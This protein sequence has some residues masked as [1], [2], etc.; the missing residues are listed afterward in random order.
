[1]IQHLQL[2][3]ALKKHGLLPTLETIANGKVIHGHRLQIGNESLLYR[4]RDD[5]ISITHYQTADN[6]GLN[7]RFKSAF[8]FLAI[9]AQALPNVQMMRADVE[10]QTQPSLPATMS[11][12]RMITFYQRKH[13]ATVY[14]RAQG[15]KWVEWSLDNIRQIGANQPKYLHRIVKEYYLEATA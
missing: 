9:V 10:P 8:I 15:P 12:E 13:G 5:Y 7:N 4:L 11:A 3:E 2:R 14:E 6:S 1:M